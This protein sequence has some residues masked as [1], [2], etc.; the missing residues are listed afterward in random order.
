MKKS[1]VH[2]RFPGWSSIPL[3]DQ[4]KRL[5]IIL[6]LIIIGY[7]F[8]RQL[9]VPETFGEF[10]HYRGAA[11]DSI[12]ALPVSYAGE[13]TCAQCHEDIHEQKNG[14]YHKNLSCEVCH[15]PGIMHAEEDPEAYVLAKPRE[16]GFCVLCHAYNA[17]RPTGFPQIDPAVHNP[18]EPCMK[19]H[20]PHDPTPP[21]VPEECSACHGE[22]ARTKAVSP[23]TNIPCIRCHVTPDEHK[24]T[25]RSIPPGKPR[26]RSFCGECHSLTADSP[27]EIPRIDLDYHEPGYLCWQCHYPHH[28]EKQP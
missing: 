16:R 8:A 1:S 25:P 27:E 18:V 10:G 6:V 22:I 3:P 26:S 21:H 9:F 28:P 23:H 12:K 24:V 4:I 2:F 13:E 5:F 14:S 17:S 15:G 19:C 7:F 20:N 11:V